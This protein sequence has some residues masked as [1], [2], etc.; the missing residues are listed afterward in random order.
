MNNNDH[1]FFRIPHWYP[2]FSAYTFKTSFVRLRPEAA[3]FLAAS[4][5][6]RKE[7]SK[8]IS[9]QVIADLKAPMSHI[10]GNCFVSVDCCAPTDTE[11]FL[12]K[13]GA[14]YSPESAWKFL[15]QSEKVRKAAAAGKAEFI[16]LRPF[17]HI[18]KAREFR[19]FIYGGELCAMSQY[20][21]IRHFPLLDKKGSVYWQMAQ[22]M[23]GSTVWELPVENF[24]MDIY[25][26][27]DNE[28]LVIDLNPWGEPTDPLLM[29]TWERDWSTPAGIVLMPSPVAVS[30]DDKGDL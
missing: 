23:V 3:A 5:E 15:C 11:R 14:V 29:R 27:S 17:R 19:L 7:L 12:K 30:R 25:I 10:H 20:W 8:N 21:L 18:N 6:E 9:R 4:D 24:V 1:E 26:T 13:K 16:C 2:Y 28:I 22:E